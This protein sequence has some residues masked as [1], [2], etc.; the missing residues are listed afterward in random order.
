LT[1]V[2]CSPSKHRIGLAASAATRLGDSTKHVRL[3]SWQ[4]PEGGQAA[5]TAGIAGMSQIFRKSALFCR[6]DRRKPTRQSCRFAICYV[7]W[8]SIR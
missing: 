8:D 7:R 6:D 2:L 1:Y 4:T 3:R 5:D